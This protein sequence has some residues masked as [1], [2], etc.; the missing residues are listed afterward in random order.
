ML[1]AQNWLLIQLHSKMG[2]VILTLILHQKKS[3]HGKHPPIYSIKEHK[4][5]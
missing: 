3:S 5:K 1:S 4:H 2:L